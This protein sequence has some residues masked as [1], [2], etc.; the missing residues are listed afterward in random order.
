M[1]LVLF[2]SSVE[3]GRIV[4]ES[5]DVDGKDGKAVRCEYRNSGC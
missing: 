2:E 1:G 4:F 5:V 3:F